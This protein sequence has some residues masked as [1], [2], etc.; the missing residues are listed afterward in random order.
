M[1]VRQDHPITSV[2]V[3]I[4]VGVNADGRREVLGMDIGA[5]EAWTAFLRKLTLRGLRGVKLVISDAHLGI[6][7]AISKVMNATSRR[8]RVHFMRNARTHA[9]KSGKPMIRDFIGKAFAQEDARSVKADWRRVADQLRP[10]VKKLADLLDKAEDDVL[11]Y[12]TFPKDH[13]TKIYSNNPISRLNREI[14]RRTNVMGILAS[15]PFGSP[16][17]PPSSGWW[18]LFCWNKTTNGRCNE[19]VT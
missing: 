10:K 3:I 18:A 8:C 17:K 6:K 12:S 13:W 7:A 9:N 2:S 11:A 5:S 14:K 1:K 19:L 15:P 16:T 4:P